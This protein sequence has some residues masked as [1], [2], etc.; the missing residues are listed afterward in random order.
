MSHIWLHD[1][2]GPRRAAVMAGAM[3][4][5]GE[6]DG[7]ALLAAIRRA[8]FAAAP[9]LDRRGLAMRLAHAYGDSLRATRLARAVAER[10]VAAALRPL[11]DARAP[12]PALLA[13]A[14]AADADGVLRED[15]RA[16]L[17]EAAIRARLR[18]RR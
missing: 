8:A 9:G 1:P 15:E 6:A 12:G 4:A 13:A 3:V 7:P 2:P 11:L 5:R 18:G 14:A 10:Q 17:V 16:A